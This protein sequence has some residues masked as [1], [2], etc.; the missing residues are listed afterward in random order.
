MCSQ[1]GAGFTPGK[2][3]RFFTRTGGQSGTWGFQN[4]TRYNARL[5]GLASTWK[6]LNQ[7]RGIIRV[8]S[9]WERDKEF[10][11]NDSKELNIGVLHNGLGEFV[12]ITTAATPVVRPFHQ[13]MPLILDDEDVQKFLDGALELREIP[14]KAA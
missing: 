13:R 10:V 3:M 6:S 1:L 11:R 8:P 7:N 9:F 5:E 2:I 14:L 12:V 4:G